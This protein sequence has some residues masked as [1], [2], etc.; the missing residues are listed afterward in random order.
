MPTDPAPR[1]ARSKAARAQGAGRTEW[2]IGSL[3]SGSGMLDEAVRALLGGGRIAWHAETDPGACAVL[4]HRYP[5]VPNLGDVSTV[6]WT[7]IEPVTVLTGGFPCQD[8]SSAGR[9]AGLRSGTRSGLW[10]SMRTAIEH[11]QPQLVV[12]ENVRGLLSAKTDGSELELCPRCMGNLDPDRVVRALGAVLGDLADLGF[13]AA[14]H[15]LPAADIGACHL[16]HR[17]FILAWRRTGT[18]RPLGRPG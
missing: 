2:T 12:A 14:W 1:A 9:R 6:D 18:A 7:R 4:A 15:G 3:F 13:D 8:V 11:L 10:A 17:V 16:R 5:D